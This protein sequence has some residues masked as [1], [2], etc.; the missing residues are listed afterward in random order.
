MVAPA[1]VPGILRTGIHSARPAA[2]DVAVGTLYA[3]S[4]H[5]T[6]DQSDGA[7]WSTYYNSN[8]SGS[9]AVLSMIIDGGGS[10]LTTGSKGFVEV[11]FAGTITAWRVMANASGS[12]VVDVKKATYSGLPSTS[13]IAAS[14][15]PTLSS[16]QKNQ[17]TTLTGWTTSVAAGDWLEF[18]VDSATTVTRVTVSITIART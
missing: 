18:N 3:C 12:V 7:T 13:S 5:G 14:A 9:T 15:K 6:I 11:P 1:T 10:T 4:T 8:L 2:T 16:A 17:D